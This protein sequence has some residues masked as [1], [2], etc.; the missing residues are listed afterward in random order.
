MCNMC[1]MAQAHAN[2][3]YSVQVKDWMNHS[4]TKVVWWADAD[5]SIRP[6]FPYFLPPP[7]PW[8]IIITH[9]KIKSAHR[10]DSGN[11]VHE[12]GGA[13]RY[14]F[15]RM[16]IHHIVL[17]LYFIFQECLRGIVLSKFSIT[18]SKPRAIALLTMY[19]GQLFGKALLVKQAT[20]HMKVNKV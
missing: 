13:L 10:L 12:G 8:F 4:K 14:L 18:L 16:R 15:Q 6:I 9:S 20:W 19:I 11:R 5:W 7:S 1:I 2:D 3:E 17:L